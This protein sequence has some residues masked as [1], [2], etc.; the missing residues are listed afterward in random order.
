VKNNKMNR[1][2]L[3]TAV[4]TL[5]F[6]AAFDQEIPVVKF[7]HLSYVLNPVD[8]K[9]I[10]ESHFI[11][12]RLIACE[13]KTARADNPSS[14][15]SIYLFG[16]SCYLELFGTAGKEDS[17]GV[18]SLAFSVDKL[19]ELNILKNIFNKTDKTLS[20]SRERDLEGV[21]V[22]WFDAMFTIDS[23]FV[24]QSRFSFWIMEY[25]AEY[26]KH[27]EYTITNN[28]MTRENYLQKYAPERKNKIVKRFSGVTMKLSPFE[29]QYLADFFM[30][31]GFKKTAENLFLLPDNFRF[32][33]ENR[34]PDDLKTIASIEFETNKS[35]AKK[36][37][38]QISDNLFIS[39]D[40][41][42]GRMIFK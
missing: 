34:A 3:C 13:T 31:L 26:F 39:I 18:S 12:E 41:H 42:S 7:N 25:R 6:M 27:N 17:L 33:L 2:V 20:V 8:L 16:P 30:R 28:K 35:F 32:S 22:P 5:L 29:K 21:K 24:A 23:T 36:E 4:I 1:A 9:A 14:Q 15:T 19:G 11:N 38:F 37:K 10:L 40:G